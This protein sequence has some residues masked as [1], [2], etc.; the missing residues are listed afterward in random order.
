MRILFFLLLSF[1]NLI[2]AHADEV[3]LIGAGATFP[4][5]LYSKMFQEYYSIKK[6]KVNYQAIGSGGGIRQLINKTVDFGASDAFIS[7]ENLKKYGNNILHIPICIGAVV[8]SYNLHGNPAIKLTPEIISNIFLGKIKKWNNPA[9]ATINPDIKLPDQQIVVIHRSDGSGTT[10]I[11]T[12]YLSKVSEEWAT[13]FG[14]GK[15]INWPIGLGAKG[16]PGVAGLI[17]QIPG[18]IGYIELV[19]ALHNNM[20]YAQVKNKNENYITPSIQSVSYAANIELPEDSRVS[21]TNTDAE[22]GYPISGFTWILTYNDL[23]NL[24]RNKAQELVNLFW[25]MT[26]EGQKLAAPLEY[27][28][29]SPKAQ[30]IAEQ[31]IKKIKYNNEILWNTISK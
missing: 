9:I 29:L 22:Q 25:W 6:V 30:S 1:L 28:P 18:S 13:K 4:Y 12:D 7:D 27:A 17:K 10:F 24:N 2:Y 16:N 14:K 20:S 21:L 19:Y 8:L 11:F 5:P 3:T 15:S 31:I 23:S 26:H